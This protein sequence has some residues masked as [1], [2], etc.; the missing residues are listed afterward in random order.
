MNDNSV[1]W[2]SRE[3]SENDC[4]REDPGMDGWVHLVVIWTSSKENLFPE[5]LS[6]Y[7][8]RYQD[9]NLHCS[10]SQL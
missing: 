6:E 4:L 8:G 7:T 10:E 3:N 9:Y 1:I 2:P 5:F